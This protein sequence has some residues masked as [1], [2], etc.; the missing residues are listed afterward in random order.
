MAFS[1]I[2]QTTRT[3]AHAITQVRFRYNSNTSKGLKTAKCLFLK[4]NLLNIIPI[5]R[6]K[7]LFDP[8]LRII[9]GGGIVN[10]PNTHRRKKF[11]R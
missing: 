9:Q 2:A 3:R 8:P 5:I 4:D 11:L 7:T 10:D 1:H 6:L